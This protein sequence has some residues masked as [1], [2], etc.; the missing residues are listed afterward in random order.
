MQVNKILRMNINMSFHYTAKHADLHVD[1]DFPHQVMIFYLQAIDFNS[2]E[3]GNKH[4][5]TV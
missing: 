2:T 3:G 4:I 5:S 1:H